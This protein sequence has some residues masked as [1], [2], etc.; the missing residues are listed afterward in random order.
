VLPILNGI[1]CNPNYA[2][3]VFSQ[4][5]GGVIAPSQRDFIQ[6]QSLEREKTVQNL[7][8][9]SRPISNTWKATF[10]KL[11]YYIQINFDDFSFQNQFF[12]KVNLMFSKV[13]LMNFFLLLWLVGL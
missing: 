1:L 13:N 2:A 9:L 8:V 6:L 5:Q 3:L 12:P 10:Q 7:V 11:S 4:L